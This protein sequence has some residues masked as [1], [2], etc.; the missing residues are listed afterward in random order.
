MTR[1]VRLNVLVNWDC[2]CQAYM[3]EVILMQCYSLFARVWSV[4]FYTEGRECRFVNCVLC[5]IKFVLGAG[6]HFLWLDFEI[7]VVVA[8]FLQLNPKGLWNPGYLTLFP[9]KIIS[10]N[11]TEIIVVS[12]FFTVMLR[13]LHTTHNFR[14]YDSPRCMHAVCCTIIIC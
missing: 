11:I 2:H 10:N 1:L 9:Y 12:K 8:A 6:K 14:S 4:V 5:K 13:I 3:Q 7:L